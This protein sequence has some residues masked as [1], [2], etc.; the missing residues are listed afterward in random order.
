[1]SATPAV[2]INATFLAG[3][4]DDPADHPGVAYLMGRVIDRGTECRSADL[5][6][7]EL[8]ARGVSLR[9][10]TTRHTTAISCTCLADD[11]DNLLSIVIDVARRPTFPEGE[12]AK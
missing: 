6:A 9:V 12:L 5:I 10:A 11:F 4:A 2:A 8:D 3:A 7:E 1:T